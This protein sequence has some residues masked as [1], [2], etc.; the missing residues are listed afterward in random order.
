MLDNAMKRRLIAASVSTIL[1]TAGVATPASAVEP[2]DTASQVAGVAPNLGGIHSGQVDGTELVAVTEHGSA[3]IGLDPARGVTIDPAATSGA[4]TDVSSSLSVGLPNE[5]SVGDGQQ[6]AD[7]SVVYPALD[8]RADVVAQALETGAVR[9]QT[10]TRTADGPHRFT[11]EFDED[12]DIVVL[13]DGS[14]ELSRDSGDGISVVVGTIET[15]WALD[16]N[17]RKVETYYEAH[18]NELVQVLR[19][20][21]DAEYPIVADPTAAPITLGVRVRFNRA[22]TNVVAS[23]TVAT[24]ATWCGGVGAALAPFA[25]GV[26]GAAIAGA[27]IAV[28]GVVIATAK[29]A[30]AN[31]QCLRIDVRGIN[32][33][34]WTWYPWYGN[35]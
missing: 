8:D 29:L 25:G 14:A 34:L 9:L 33:A 20:D 27:C 3:T 7:G 15:P 13:E 6:T 2:D 21:K 19:P 22:E 11:Y 32:P 35:C 16:A 18:E 17:G 28:S 5:V 1:L 4:V 12:L 31:S 26:G 23:S 24:A 10:V 30:R